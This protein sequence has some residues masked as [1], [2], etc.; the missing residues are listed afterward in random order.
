VSQLRIDKLSY[1]AR[2]PI[3]LTI[4]AGECVGLSG[5]SGA[6]K[7]LLLRAIVDLDPHQGCV[8]LDQEACADVAAPL[9]RR[10]VGLLPAESQ[11]W[12]E[13]VGEHF[14]DIEESSLQAL[15][16]EKAVMGWQV[17]RLS[18][19]ERQ[20]LGLI[21][22]LANQ[23][24]VMLLDEPT[25]NLDPDNAAKAE[26]L[27]AN[28]SRTTGA[29]VIWVSHDAQQLQRVAHRRFRIEQGRLTEQPCQ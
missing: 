9:W 8:Y 1:Q 13:T 29:P 22:L 16:F 20:R 18:S 12:F 28:Y 11:W 4:N 6:G 10:Q 5:P 17:S 27:I 24:K 15:G 25:A 26:T 19:G 23:P 3:N 2:G 21:R 14:A 7:T